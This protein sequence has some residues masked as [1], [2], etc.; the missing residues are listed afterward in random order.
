MLKVSPSTKPKICFI[1]PVAINSEGGGGLKRFLREFPSYLSQKDIPYHLFPLKSR[2]INSKFLS[3]IFHIFF[4]LK[5]VIKVLYSH[6]KKEFQIIHAQDAVYCGVTGLFLS[7]MLHLPLITHYHNSSFY[8][9]SSLA[10]VNKKLYYRIV[11][12]FLL[13]IEKLVLN[14]SSSIIVTN[15]FLKSLLL[16]WGISESKISVITMGVDLDQFKPTPFNNPDKKVFRSQLGI[17]FDALVIGYIGRVS[18]G[19]GLDVFIRAFSSIQ[20]KELFCP[21]LLLIVGEGEEFHQLKKLVDKLNLSKLVIFTGYRRDVDRLLSIIDIFV[22]PSFS[23][24][25]PLAILEAMASGKAIVS[26]KIPP[27]EEIIKNGVNGCLTKPGDPKEL[28]EAIYELVIDNVKRDMLSRNAFLKAQSY[29]IKQ[30]FDRIIDIY[31]NVLFV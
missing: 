16:S 9:Y 18:H 22:Y 25:S 5:T 3:P 10:K 20:K 1:T 31:K 6:K 24:G 23:E 8:I 12:L 28:E 11:L 30:N 27:I 14:S 21:T 19:K 29:D 2:H 17:H 15:L 7:I 4:V 13:L 26:T